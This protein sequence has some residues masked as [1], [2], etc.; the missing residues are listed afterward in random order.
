MPKLRISLLFFWNISYLLTFLYTNYKLRGHK[1]NWTNKIPYPL[2]PKSKYVL[3]L[4]YQSC[5]PWPIIASMLWL[6]VSLEN[7]DLT[8]LHCP[9]TTIDKVPSPPATAAIRPLEPVCSQEAIGPYHLN[10]E[11]FLSNP[12]QEC[13]TIDKNMTLFWYPFDKNH[14]RFS[15][16]FRWNKIDESQNRPRF[17]PN[18]CLNIFNNATYSC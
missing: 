3:S 11:K 6:L 15:N 14:V 17:L 7:Y 1:N 18:D 5:V 2:P 13:I 10:T 16:F 8:Y 4:R 12:R 9:S